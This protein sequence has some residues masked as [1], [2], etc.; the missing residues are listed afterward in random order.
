[1]SGLSVLLHRPV[2][3]LEGIIRIP[4]ADPIIYPWVLQ[5]PT[6][7][8]T[9]AGAGVEGMRAEQGVRPA[10]VNHYSP[11]AALRPQ[12]KGRGAKPKDFSGVCGGGPGFKG[13]RGDQL[14]RGGEGRRGGSNGSVLKRRCGDRVA[15]DTVSQCIEYNDMLPRSKVGKL[16]RRKIRDE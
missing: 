11:R 6:R 8:I 15:A 12:P 13:G 14:H 16:L 10:M 1:M 4:D 2:V 9:Y 5:D 7:N 3:E